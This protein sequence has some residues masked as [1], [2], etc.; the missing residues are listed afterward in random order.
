MFIKYDKLVIKVKSLI[1][2]AA[3][4]EDNVIGRGPDIPWE[5]PEDIQH[6]EKLTMGHPVIMGRKTYESI[7]EKFRPLP[8]RTNIV[9][10]RSP[11]NI[12]YSEG[13]ITCHSLFEARR[14][15]SNLNKTSYVIG[16]GQIYKQTIGLASRL[17]IT[18]VHQRVEGDVF[19]PEINLRVWKETQREDFGEYSFVTYERRV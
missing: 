7:P 16:G 1:L 12:D 8:D 9:I 19:F 15:R 18:E 2:I 17:E 5:I 13:V 10:S 14:E 6:F 4:A 3:V 11:E